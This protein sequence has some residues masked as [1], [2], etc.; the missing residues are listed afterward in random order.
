M[1]NSIEYVD[2]NQQLEIILSC[3]SL[4]DVDTFSKSD[5]F[6]ILYTKINDNCKIQLFLMQGVEYSRTEVIWNSLNPNFS[7]T[8]LI[9]C[10]FE[11]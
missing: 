11:I 7:K 1:L 3:R 2:A 9:D 6:I 8:I 10:F 5:P 4:A